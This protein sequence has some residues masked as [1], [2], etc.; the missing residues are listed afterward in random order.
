MAGGR[1]PVSEKRENKA[2]LS[3]LVLVLASLGGIVFLL[4]FAIFLDL[5]FTD[6]IVWFVGLL[7]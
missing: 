1:R 3:L 6:A 5:M 7:S 2:L 4:P